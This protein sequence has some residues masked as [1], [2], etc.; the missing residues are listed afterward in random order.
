MI[1]L[2]NSLGDKK[3]IIF[4]NLRMTCVEGKLF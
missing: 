3:N 2:K 1:I 4:K